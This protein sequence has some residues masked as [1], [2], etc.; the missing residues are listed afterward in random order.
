MA[1]A[2]LLLPQPFGP[3]M[4][5]TPWSKASSDAVGKRLEAGDFETFEAHMGLSRV[6]S[7]NKA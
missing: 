6:E 3:T 5:V 4:A 1:S 7:L 2:T